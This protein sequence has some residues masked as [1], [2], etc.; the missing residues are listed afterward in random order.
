MIK[1]P[2]IGAY[3]RFK[4]YEKNKIAIHDLCRFWKYFSATRYWKDTDPE[5][6]Y[7]S[8]SQKHVACS[9]VYKLKCVDDKFNKC[10]KSYL[11]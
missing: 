11:G 1:M 8:K 3:V 2:I 7:M 5:E 4:N 10:F 6:S 9:Y